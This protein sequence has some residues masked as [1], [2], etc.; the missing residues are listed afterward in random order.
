MKIGPLVVVGPLV[1]VGPL[2]ELGPLPSVISR[3]GSR[4]YA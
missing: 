1:K 3:E 2:A 4:A